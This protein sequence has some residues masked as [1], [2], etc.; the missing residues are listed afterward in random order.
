MNKSYVVKIARPERAWKYQMIMKFISILFT[1]AI[2][3]LPL[4][5]SATGSVERASPANSKAGLFGSSEWP[6]SGAPPFPQWR[7]MLSRYD[8]ETQ[9]AFDCSTMEFI[10]ICS[11]GEWQEI[12]A[13]LSDRPVS[14]QLDQVNRYVNRALYIS[15][16][17]N[18]GVPDYWATVGEFLHKDGDCEDYAIAKYISLKDLEFPVDAMRIVVVEDTNLQTIHAVL[19][20][21]IKGQDF[22]L[23]NQVPYVVAA[24]SVFHYRPIYSINENGWWLHREKVS[25]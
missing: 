18:W 11:F 17:R 6:R 3:W 9:A 14:E 12:V 19:V 15:D 25:R 10:H 23:D 1:A 21:D 5:A 7:D 4:T 22:V 8:D 20:V 13:D 2:V 16:Y 24:E